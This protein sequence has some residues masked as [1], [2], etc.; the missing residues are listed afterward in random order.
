ME[1]VVVS[2]G[3]QIPNNLVMPLHAQGVPIVGTTPEK[4]DNAE[5]R[6]KF[7]DLMDSIGVDQPA[8]S[9]LTTLEEAYDFADRVSYPVLVRPS[10]VLSGAAMRVVR[11]AEALEA[12]L[13]AAATVSKEHPVVISKFIVGAKEIEFDG[14]GSQGEVIV[15]AIHEHVE[16]V[17]PPV[18]TL[19][20]TPHI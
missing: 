1:G 5:D 16:N 14:V 12:F 11:S 9:S 4:I 3:G 2:V 10:Y 6:Q 15:H 8:W 7:S 19:S 20:Q 17:S 13:E 18:P